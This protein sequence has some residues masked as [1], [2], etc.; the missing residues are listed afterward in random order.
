MTSPADLLTRFAPSPT[1]YLHLGH[2][3][4]AIW[5]WGIARARG[6]RVLLRLE[7]HDRTRCRPAFERALLEDLEWLGFEP[8]VGPIAGFRDGPSPFRQGDCGEVYE[9]ALARLG[10]GA[11]VYACDCSRRTIAAELGDVANRETPYPGRCRERG[12]EPGPGRG[13]RVAL[14]PG[15]VRF[16]DGLLGEQ[17]Q[18]PAR[19][20]G[21]LLLRDRLGQWTYQFAVTVDDMRHGVNLVIRGEDLLPS[22]GRQILLAGML[23]RPEPPMFFHHPLIRKPGGAKL[24]KADR[25]TGIREMR[26]A[27]MAAAEVIGRAAHLSGL[28]PEPTPLAP[29]E[30]AALVSARV[31]G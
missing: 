27:G 18:E 4:N 14:P 26:A 31:G 30:A 2:V 28:L 22:T 15:V 21:D 1:G 25:D 3:V 6:A 8:D 5:V 10:G 12:L 29:S 9:A 16:V 23:G 11:L 19:Q 7:D 13:I 24:S 20:C 17:A